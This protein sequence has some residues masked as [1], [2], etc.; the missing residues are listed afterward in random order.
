LSTISSDIESPQH[1]LRIGQVP[2]DPSGGRWNLL[3][4]GGCGEDAV[5]LGQV[6]LLEHVDD[7][8]LVAVG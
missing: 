7:A 5:L 2:E 1:L 6:W 8:Q 4:E 3:D